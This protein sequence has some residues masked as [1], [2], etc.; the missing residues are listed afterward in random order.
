SD[1]NNL[2]D[3]GIDFTNF[4]NGGAIDSSDGSWFCTPDDSQGDAGDFQNE[5]CESGNGVLVARLTVRDLSASVYFE[6]LFQGKDA[7]GSTWQTGGSMSI[8]YDDCNGSFCDGDFNQDGVVDVSDLLNVI[9][10]WGNPY[11]VADLLLVIADWGCT[12]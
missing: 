12:G 9:A 6:A 5:S 3:I 1:D 11:D 10:N 7:S 8:V 4:Q 2:S